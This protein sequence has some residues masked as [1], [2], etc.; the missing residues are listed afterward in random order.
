MAL[1]KEIVTKAVV[2][3]GK[4]YFENSYN[5]ETEKKPTT[6]LGCWVINHKFKG[7]KTKDKIGV[8]GSYDVNIWYSYDN[9]SKTMV[10]NKKVE[11]NDLFNV[12]IKDSADLSDNPDIIVRTLKQPTV[13]K[14]NIKDDG[15]I[16]FNIEKELGVEIVGETKMKIAIEEDEEP[17]EVIEDDLTE[18]ENQSID[19]QIDNTVDENNIN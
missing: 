16:D 15:S 8:D 14:V 18:E 6:V 2:G 17:W 1:Y 9:D 5:L 10:K 4:K 11:Y 12:K 7:Y 3:K 13:T 19:E